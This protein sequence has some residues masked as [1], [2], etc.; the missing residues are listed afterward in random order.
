MKRFR[1]V[2]GFF[3]FF[4]IFVPGALLG[5]E[6][7]PV[8]SLFFRGV[9]AYRGERYVEALQMLEFLDRV[10]P[11]HRRATGSLLMQGKSLYKIGEHHKALDVFERLVEAYP[12]S[13]YVDDALYGM[14]T[15]FYRLGLYRDAVERLVEVVET[16]GDN[17]LL[18]KAA[19]LS[20]EIMDSHLNAG[21][22]RTLLETI[23]GERGRAAVALRLAQREIEKQ[24]FQSAKDVLQD[25]VNRYPKSQYVFQMEQLLGRAERLGKGFLKLGVVL[26]LSGPRSE[27]GKELLGGIQY[28]VD[29]HNEEEG[30]K[31]ELVVRVHR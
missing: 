12:N 22:L 14:A 5:Q 10:Y 3:F 4:G 17:R 21:D 6:T 24:H 18:R 2:I 8:D 11:G 30:A 15:A 9:S 20:S 31:V 7:Q 27:E 13:E 26:P 29:I 1:G 16:S 23:S 28:A 19:K 25:F